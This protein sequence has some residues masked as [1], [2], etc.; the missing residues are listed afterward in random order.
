M[1]D[2]KQKLGLA[3]QLSY[4]ILM[5]NI[6]CNTKIDAE[7]KQILLMLLQERDRNFVRLNDNKQVFENIKS[8]LSLVKPLY[9][10]VSKL[11]RVGGENDG[12][13]VMFKLEGTKG[14][15][16]SLGVSHRSPWDLDMAN[17]GFKVYQYDREY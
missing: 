17:L 2:L 16:L 5:S 7:D 12:G 13:Y 11:V 1:E 6:I 15:A 3:N 14:T 10:P 4:N 8:Y 9:L